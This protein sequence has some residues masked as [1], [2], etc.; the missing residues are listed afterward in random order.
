ML[1]SCAHRLDKDIL[2]EISSSEDASF[3]SENIKYNLYDKV[4]FGKF[5]KYSLIWTVI[6]SDD[7]KVTLYSD[8]CFDA[9]MSENREYREYSGGGY[10]QSYDIENYF[11][12]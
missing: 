9:R 5:G 1:S 11:S 12:R 8:Y 10:S 2:D 3:S 7:D 4:I 6:D